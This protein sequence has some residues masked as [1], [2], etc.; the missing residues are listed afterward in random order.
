M[1]GPQESQSLYI[2]EEDWRKEGLPLVQEDCVRDQLT[3]L[4][5]YKSV[6]PNGMHPKVVR[7]LS[8]VIAEPLSIVFERSWR[9]GEVPEG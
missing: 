2:S 3:K 4:D 9:T 6:G 8:D 1:A 7:E 5:T